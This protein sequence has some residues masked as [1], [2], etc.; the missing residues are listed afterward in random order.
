MVFRY[1]EDSTIKNL[2]PY[3]IIKIMDIDGFYN[4]CI[5]GEGIYDILLEKYF[6]DTKIFTEENIQ[7]RTGYLFEHLNSFKNMLNNSAKIHIESLRDINEFLKIMKYGDKVNNNYQE[8]D[9]FTKSYSQI[10]PFLSQLGFIELSEYIHYSNSSNIIINFKTSY[11]NDVYYG[12]Y[13]FKILYDGIFLSFDDMIYDNSINQLTSKNIDMIPFEKNSDM[14]P[15]TYLDIFLK[16]VKYTRMGFN[17]T[18][19]KENADEFYSRFLSTNWNLI[20][21]SIFPNELYTY[22]YY[23]LTIRK[24]FFKFFNEKSLI[25]SAKSNEGLIGVISIHDIS[26]PYLI[27]YRN[28]IDISQN[29]IHNKYGNINYI[30]ECMGIAPLSIYDLNYILPYIDMESI[31]NIGGK[32]YNYIVWC[33]LIKHIINIIENTEE[34]VNIEIINIILSKFSN[35]ERELKNKI[36]HEFKNNYTIYY[37]DI[38]LKNIHVFYFISKLFNYFNKIYIIDPN[39][40]QITRREIGY[41]QED[42]TH[43]LYRFSEDHIYIEDE[44]EKFQKIFKCLENLEEISPFPPFP[45]FTEKF[46]NNIYKIRLIINFGGF[47]FFMIKNLIRLYNFIRLNYIKDINVII[48]NDNFEVPFWVSV[49]LKHDTS[50]NQTGKKRNRDDDDYELPSLKKVKEN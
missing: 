36:I 40:E 50:E 31:Y 47:E 21:I 46:K 49:D 18:I 29:M 2:L 19:N 7:Q 10:L 32:C 48:I 6:I 35:F 43:M 41:Y 23:Y 14:N 37:N 38:N 11:H 33:R 30:P 26:D 9:I 15:E 42:L 24:E 28:I 39:G 16:I 13:C 5:S 3:E 34:E 1:F 25:I 44:I 17:V 27:Q 45:C 12:A 8:F 22:D 20:Y 4:T